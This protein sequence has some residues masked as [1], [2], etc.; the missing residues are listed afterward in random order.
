MVFRQIIVTALN[1]FENIPGI[2]V[3]LDNHPFGIMSARFH[4]RLKIH[5]SGAYRNL[6]VPLRSFYR[7]AV[8]DMEE[9]CTGTKIFYNRYRILS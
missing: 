5:Y 2:L 6:L 7:G 3:K 4:N 1:A 9:W 8:F